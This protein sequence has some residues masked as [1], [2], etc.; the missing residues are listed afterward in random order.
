MDRLGL[1]KPGQ[2]MLHL[3]P[4]KALAPYFRSILGDGYDP[5]D[6]DPRR[7]P[8]EQ[9][10]QLDLV[11]D[12]PKLPSLTYDIVLHSHVMEHIPCNVTAVLF[13]LHRALKE[14]GHHV[15]SIPM[16]VGATY[17]ADFG[18]LSPDKAR[19][20]FGQHDHVRRFGSEDV[21]RTLGMIFPL[22]DRYDIEAEYGADV[23]TE[24]NV[25]EYAWRGWSPHTVMDFRKD[26]F[27][28]SA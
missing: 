6:I 15:F 9:V 8:W 18:P 25:P 26:E 10:R 1:P 5:V 22:P 14:D 27:L 2:R 19:H 13:H 20:E 7:Y 28:L 16:R 17:A 4:E 23:L 21:D 12:S 11:T 24:A 3:A